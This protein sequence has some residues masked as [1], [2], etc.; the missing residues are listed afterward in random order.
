MGT[1]PSS[2]RK[3]DH[4]PSAGLMWILTHPSCISFLIAQTLEQQNDMRKEKRDEQTC[5]DC[6]WP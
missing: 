6:P 4:I 2:L 3:T 5:L 1:R